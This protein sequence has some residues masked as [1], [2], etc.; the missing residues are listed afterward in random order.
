MKSI[1]LGTWIKS[2][3]LLE[4]DEDGAILKRMISDK[5]AH[6]ASGIANEFQNRNLNNWL[7]VK[8]NSYVSLEDLEKAVIPSFRY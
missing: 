6:I 8:V 3:P 5:D 7:Q 2:N 4:L 1:N